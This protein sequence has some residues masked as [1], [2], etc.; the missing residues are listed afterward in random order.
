MDKFFIQTINGLA[1]GM[2]YALIASGVTLM[3]GIMDFINMAHG[4][5][6]ML[7]AYVAWLCTLHVFNNFW[8]AL[9][10]GVAAITLMGAGIRYAV[11]PVLGKNPLYS[12]LATYG[13]GL[14]L[15]QSILAIFGPFSK[16]LKTP[17][18]YKLFFFGFEYSAYRIL[19]IVISLAVI[20]GSWLFMKKSKYG[21]WIR[22]V[23]QDKEMASCMGLPI[24]FIY[25]LIFCLGA[26]MAA[27]GGIIAAPLFGVHP[28]MGTEVILTAFIIVMIGG[29]GNFL[30]SIIAAILIGE[31]I[32]MG[33]LL[34]AP[35]Q[36]YVL[37]LLILLLVLLIRPEGLARGLR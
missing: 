36:A 4:E 19:I 16:D 13:L 32:A 26:A 29:L 15:Q 1:Y 5:L 6:Y 2:I 33:S 20:G 9:L 22:A 18:H 31:A 10:V 14:A 21:I 11:L 35:T 34:L 24:P 8:V 30:G 7:G 17:I 37:A 27:L 25:T 12:L 23:A 28:T 3:W